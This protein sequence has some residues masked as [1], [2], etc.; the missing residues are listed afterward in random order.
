MGLPYYRKCPWSTDTGCGT[1]VLAT[2]V[3]MAVLTHN[4][5]LLSCMLPFEEK[6]AKTEARG[7]NGTGKN[8]KKP[9]DARATR[10]PGREHQS[11]NT[12]A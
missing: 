6:E 7:G 12:D 5:C 3:P 9:C 4:R 10:P 1:S 8:V 11:G 2:M